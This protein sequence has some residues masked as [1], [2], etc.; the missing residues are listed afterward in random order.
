MKKKNGLR[1]MKTIIPISV[2]PVLYASNEIWHQ[3][4]P[5]MVSFSFFETYFFIQKYLRWT[6]K[7]LVL[8]SFSLKAFNSINSSFRP[9]YENRLDKFQIIIKGNKEV[10]S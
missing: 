7:I 1:T 8:V 4:I 2:Q 10:K 5:R 6:L 9:N 3:Q